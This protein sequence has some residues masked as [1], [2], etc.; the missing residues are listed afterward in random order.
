MASIHL[1]E[2]VS[3]KMTWRLAEN[4]RGVSGLVKAGAAEIIR[5]HVRIITSERIT[6][7]QL[8]NVN[9][10]SDDLTRAM[11]ELQQNVPQS[12]VCDLYVPFL[13]TRNY[14]DG[15]DPI[16]AMDLNGHKRRQTRL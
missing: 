7:K 9:T 12:V 13:V 8:A 4:R 2:L 1:W 5:V 14:H 10:T 16:F 6:N 3:E 11:S 15:R